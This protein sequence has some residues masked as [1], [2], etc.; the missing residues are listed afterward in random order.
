MGGVGAG[1]RDVE[2]AGLWRGRGCG[3]GFGDGI[4]G[5]D[6]G[7]SRGRELEGKVG[8]CGGQD[9]VEN[10]AGAMAGDTV[11]G[12]IGYCRGRERG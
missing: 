2:R 12:S 1:T 5:H 4:W 8:R 11:K 3:K 6:T 10:V 7:R 9:E